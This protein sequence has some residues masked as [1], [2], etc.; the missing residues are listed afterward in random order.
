MSLESDR[1]AAEV[2]ALADGK[3]SSVEIARMLDANPRRVRK[4]LL[5]LNL[6]RLPA[7]SPTGERN[8]S[9]AG[10][11]RIA[12]DG[13]VYV[14]APIGHPYAPCLPKKNIPL[15]REHRL[16]LEKHLGRYLLPGEIV[17]HIDGLTLHNH[18]DN[19]RLFASNADHLHETRAGKAPL[20]SV[21]GKQ[22]LFLRHRP[23]VI[24]QLV[25]THGQ[26]K[27]AGALRLR[28]I[29]LAALKLGTD[30]PYLLGSSRHTTTA[31]IDMSSRSTIE[32]ALADL[33]VRWGW[34][35]VL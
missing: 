34:P 30:S 3:T 12:L 15:I 31:G 1:F 17:D 28:Q 32:R 11:R 24:L 4:V 10:G 18:L 22:N 8:S 35:L 20:W 19:L 25:D 29:L 9:F 21:E 23:G 2:T 6:P 27:A 33:C 16:V 26:R 5:R 14:S 13:Y 7:H